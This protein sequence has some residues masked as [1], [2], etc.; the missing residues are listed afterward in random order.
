M[1]N[2]N[3]RL[4]NSSALSVKEIKAGL[5]TKVIGNGILLFDSVTSTMDTARKEIERTVPEG[6]VIFAEHQSVGKGRRS[7]V[8]SCPKMKG[9]LT[10]VILQ[11]KTP[12]DQISFLMGISSIAVVEAIDHFLNIQAQ[13]K[14]PN[15]IIINKK[16]VAG[17]L[18]EA[19]GSYNQ[20]L[21]FAI[22]IGI[23]VNLTEKELPDDAIFPATSLA[24]ETGS[25]TNR[26]K[27][28]RI[29]LQ[30]LDTWYSYLQEN[31]YEFIRERWRD[32]CLRFKQKLSISEGIRNYTGRFAD[33][34][35]KGDLVLK[36]DNNTERTFEGKHI[37]SFS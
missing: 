5:N 14:W 34:T 21:T 23:N 32:L 15:D 4:K 24:L 16:K 35:S 13:V 18:I 36:L 25:C 28:A 31:Q 26:I 6:L 33:I 19:H 20:T 17:I 27:L 11:P 10:T 30:S 1:E 37:T 2:M 22:G 9:L 8:W 3:H 12:S 7:R 29:L